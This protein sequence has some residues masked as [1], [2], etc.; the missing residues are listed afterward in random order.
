MSIEFICRL[1]TP[2]GAVV[3][4]VRLAD[5][6]ASLRRELAGA[7]YHVFELR[8]KSW[9]GRLQLPALRG[10]AR[11]IAPRPFLVFNQELAALLRA[12]LPLLQGLDMMVERVQEADLRRVLTDVRNRVRGGE[13][14]SSAVAAQGEVFPSLYASTL[15]AGERTGEL[16]T[17]I[18]R[19]IRYQ[20]LMIAARKRIVSALTYPAVLVGLA[21]SLIT[22]MT[23]FVVPR[24]RSFYTAMD[25]KLPLLTRITLRISE[26][27]HAVWPILL[28]GL[29]LA[30]WVGWR[31]MH[32]PS[33]REWLNRLQLRLPLLGDVFRRLALAEF[34]RSSSTLLLGGLPLPAALEIAVASVGNSAIRRQLDPVTGEVREGQALHDSLE[35]RKVFDH[36]E[37]DMVSVGEATGSLGQM[38]TEVADFLDEEVETRLQRL[39]GLIEPLMLVFMG[40]IVALLLASIYLPLFSV[41]QQIQF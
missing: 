25:A 17:V 38:L 5:D 40:M 20:R 41:M 29:I 16:E 13:E 10:R 36:L 18:R 24:F 27:L 14:L 11:R 21:I 4:E 7:G 23:I 32:S 6:E 8:P 26:G 31:L 15:K 22:I 35:R 1:G 30:A 19:F 3:R 12:G 39:L 37:I 34:C 33:G 2:T 28:G 9:M